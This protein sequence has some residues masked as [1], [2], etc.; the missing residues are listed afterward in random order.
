MMETITISGW[1]QYVTEVLPRLYQ[2]DTIPTSLQKLYE[3]QFQPLFKASEV[4]SD[5]FCFQVVPSNSAQG[6]F[7]HSMVDFA[8]SR[9]FA[10]DNLERFQESG[11]NSHLLIAADAQNPN[12]VWATLRVAWGPS[13]DVFQLFSYPPDQNQST[14]INKNSIGSIGR[15]GL[16]PLFDSAAVL[17]DPTVHERFNHVRVALT[18]KLAQLGVAALKEESVERVYLIAT[19]SIH[20]WLSMCGI[21]SDPVEGATIAESVA[22][23]DFR[24]RYPGYWESSPKLYQLTT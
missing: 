8:Y 10:N 12:I 6:S 15:M 24:K 5:T 3:C 9:R 16:H 13:I 21:E 4:I 19:E 22:V 23:I 18:S 11:T 20:L 2:P 1:G 14:P 7:A 17:K